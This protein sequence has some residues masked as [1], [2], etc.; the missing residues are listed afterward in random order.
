MT[1]V[2]IKFNNLQ[3]G[4]LFSYLFLI[5]V[6]SLL[7]VVGLISL[8]LTEQIKENVSYNLI[9]KNDM[10]WSKEYILEL[11]TSQAA[12]TEKERFITQARNIIYKRLNKANLEEVSIYKETLNEKDVLRV[13]VKTSKDEILVD[14]LIQNRFFVKVVT[15]KE[16]VDFEN[17][18]NQYAYLMGENYNP[19]E[20]TGS[21]FRNVFL[22][23]LKD[24]SGEYSYFAVFKL[25]LT[26]EKAFQDFLKDHEEETIGLEIDGFVTPYHVPTSNPKTFAISMS[27]GESQAQML[28]L[29]YNSG[30]IPLPFTTIETKMIDVEISTLN[31]IKLSI[32]LLTGIILLYLVLLFVLKEDPQLT[33]NSLFS[34]LLTIAMWI[35]YLKL[36]STP[37]DTWLLALECILAVILIY[38]L[39]H[40]RESQ[41]AITISLVF[42]FFILIIL[43]IGYMKIFGK[44]MLLVLILCQFSIVFSKWYLNNMK[45]I[46]IK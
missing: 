12:D 32:A 24:G 7:I 22:T 2:K 3:L 26:K 19:T 34:T 14:N 41:S 38:V 27:G 35:S 43:G 17:E 11:D 25:W 15:K 10:Y 23:K 1:K 46:L 37:V 9:T 36:S 20:F 40:N 28:N 5:L 44:E 16:D 29:L 21:S 42:S 8:P 39:V 30:E 45:K 18:E 31:Y 33:S 4:S 6:S 13:V